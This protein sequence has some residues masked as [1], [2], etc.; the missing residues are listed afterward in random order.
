[1]SGHLNQLPGMLFVLNVSFV[2][3]GGKVL[4][5]VDEHSVSRFENFLYYF[6]VIF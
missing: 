1:M 3:P 4:Y 2:R 5:R 6:A